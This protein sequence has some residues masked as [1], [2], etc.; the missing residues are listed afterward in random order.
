MAGCCGAARPNVSYEVTFKGGE[1]SV[2]VA[3][4]QE[5]RIAVSASSKGG[6]YKAVPKGKA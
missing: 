1:P 4:I 5:A 2:T 6:T 3:T